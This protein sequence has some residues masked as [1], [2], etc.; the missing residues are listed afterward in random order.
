MRF[1]APHYAFRRFLS[2][3]SSHWLLMLTTAI[4]A[5]WACLQAETRTLESAGAITIASTRW[6]TISSTRSTWRFRSR[7]SYPVDDQLV[8]RGVL[9]LVFAGA[10]GH[11]LEE[12][13]GQRL[14]DQGDPRLLR[15]RLRG[16]GRWCRASFG[17][18]ASAPMRRVE[19]DGEL[20]PGK[21]REASVRIHGFLRFHGS[22]FSTH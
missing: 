19:Q 12:L 18:S 5:S 9:A 4:P 6:A 3:V 17:R 21:P 2:P 7:S 13:V 20:P 14:H 22:G 1:N 8:L 11:R 10:V 16:R 15:L